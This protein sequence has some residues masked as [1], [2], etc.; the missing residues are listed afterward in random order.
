VP[1]E[2]VTAIESHIRLFPVLVSHYTRA[3][4]A[5]RKYLASDISLK[6][7]YN[8]YREN[9]IANNIEPQKLWMYRKVFCNKFNLSFHTPRKDTCKKCDLFKVQHET[10]KN[11]ER[12][13]TLAIEHEVHLMKAEAARKALQKESTNDRENYDAFSFDL[14]KVLPLPKLTTNEAYYCRQLSVY[15][16]GIHSLINGNGIMHIWDESIASRGSEE[17]GSC[18]FKYCQKKSDEGVRKVT[19]YSDACGGQNR[20]SKVVL[21]WMHITQC[22]NITEINHKFMASGHSFM[23]SDSD[24]G[25]IENAT[26]KATE[27]YVPEQWCDIILKCNRKHPFTVVQMNAE[28]FLSIR[29]LQQNLTVR[30]VTEDGQTKIEWLKIQWIQIRKNEPCKMYFKYSI[31]NDLEFYCANFAKRG[32]AARWPATLKELYPQQPRP[33]SAEKLRDIKKLLKYVPPIHHHFYDRLQTNVAV[34][35]THVYDDELLELSEDEMGEE[36]SEID[37]S[38]ITLDTIMDEG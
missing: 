35:Y 30:K 10:E 5:N 8:L 31:Q 14:Q 24:F 7:M 15:N 32:H 20:N 25:V 26:N 22:T 34:P 11:T 1:D 37:Q 21:M 36:I 12:K 13:Q 9:C 23:P 4:S 38:S 33:V 17:V 29:E 18:L 28:M 16:L 27:L 3:H 19:A 6:Q 2:A